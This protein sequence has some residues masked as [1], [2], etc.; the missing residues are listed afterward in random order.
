MIENPY[1]AIGTMGGTF[2]SNLSRNPSF[3]HYHYGS[4]DILGT[5]TPSQVK[6]ANLNGLSVIEPRKNVVYRKN[7]I[8]FYV[9]K[10]QHIL[11]P[12]NVKTVED[13][14][15]KV[16]LKGHSDNAIICLIHAAFLD[17]HYFFAGQQL[18][19]MKQNIVLPDA[20]KAILLSKSDPSFHHL[21]W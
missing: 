17:S 20:V 11:K 16:I 7:L 9:A 19:C 21:H 2:L 14:I 10:N 12:L 1:K 15:L 3:V 8:E 6:F 18:N 13:F 5:L 4:S